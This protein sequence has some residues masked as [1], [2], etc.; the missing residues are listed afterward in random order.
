MHLYN[1][2]GARG[3][4]YMHL[5]TV[6]GA[7]GIGYM[8]FYIVFGARGTGYMLFIMF[9]AHGAPRNESNGIVL[10]AGIDGLGALAGVWAP[11][12]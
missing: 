6:F 11:W 10:R 12:A 3:I 8:H 9:L 7:R 5:Y 2:S 1:V 4:G